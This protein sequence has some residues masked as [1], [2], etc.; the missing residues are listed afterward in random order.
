MCVWYNIIFS[1]LLTDIV[2]SQFFFIEVEQYESFQ[3][4]GFAQQLATAQHIHSTYLARNSYFE[5]N[6]DDKVRRTVSRALE[7][8]QL[9]G[10][11][12]AA[13]RAVYELLES[14]YMRFLTTDTYQSM[15]DNCGMYIKP[16]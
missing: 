3:Y 14:S 4:T 13:K 9:D 6:F 12:D 1:C 11:F 8:K 15:V 10:C 5:V 16:R 7:E 2:F